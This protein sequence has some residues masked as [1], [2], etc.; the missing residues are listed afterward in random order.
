MAGPLSGSTWR[1]LVSAPPCSSH[2]SRLSTTAPGVAAAAVVGVRDD[3]EDA[4]VRIL[5]HPH[6]ASDDLPLFRDRREDLP[7]D[8]V[9]QHLP[10]CLAHTRVDPSH[11]EVGREPP[12]RERLRGHDRSRARHSLPRRR[13]VRTDVPPMRRRPLSER[14]R[15]RL[16][17][18]DAGVTLKTVSNPRLEYASS[19]IETLLSAPTAPR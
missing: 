12:S 11:L 17:G 15:W 8:G 14:T 6:P 4:E 10:R 18:T 1:R 16:A 3:V 13:T 9:Q 7:W 19:Q 5:S 2:L